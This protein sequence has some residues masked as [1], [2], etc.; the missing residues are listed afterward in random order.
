MPSSPPGVCNNHGCGR[1]THDRYCEQHKREK[2]Q[3]SDKERGT[4]AQ[5]GYGS[6][7][8][9]ARQGY[10]AHHPLCVMCEADNVL[11]VATVVDH[12][13]PHKGDMKLFWDRKNWQ[14]LCKRHHDI[15][16]AKQDGGFGRA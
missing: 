11:N 8:R 15:K 4:A 10:L 16:T 3:R 14:P 5:R 12:I 9:K 1:I 2:R 7:W 6:K 13:L